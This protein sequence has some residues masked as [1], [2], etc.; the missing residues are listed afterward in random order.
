MVKVKEMMQEDLIHNFWISNGGIIK[1]RENAGLTPLFLYHMKMNLFWN[2]DFYYE[3]NFGILLVFFFLS[4]SW[5]ILF[6][7]FYVQELRPFFPL[8]CHFVGETP[9]YRKITTL[10]LHCIT[11]ANTPYFR[12]E[13]C[14]ELRREANEDTPRYSCL[15]SKVNK[16]ICVTNDNNSF[17]F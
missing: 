13:P 10:C 1:I 16:S 17:Y 6:K 9:A 2:I 14:F 3:F 7:T 12:F 8:F 11:C 4:F 15:F 5:V